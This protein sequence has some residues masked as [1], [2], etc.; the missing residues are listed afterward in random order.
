MRIGYLYPLVIVTG[1][2]ASATEVGQEVAVPAL[3][4]DAELEAANAL[5][6]VTF[7]LAEWAG[8]VTAGL[9]VSLAGIKPAIYLD[10]ATFLI[11]AACATALP[12]HTRSHTGPEPIWTQFTRGFGLLRHYRIVTVITLATVGF[13]AIDGALQVFWPVYSRRILGGGPAT[14]GI[15]ISAAGAGSL[16]S[17][18][19]LTT[20]M[21]KLPARLSL[22]ACLAGSGACVLALPAIHTMPVAVAAAIG[23]GVL[24]A[25]FYPISRAVLQRA[26]PEHHRGRVFGARVALT[27]W[28]PHRRRPRRHRADRRHTDHRRPGHRSHPPTHRTDTRRRQPTAHRTPARPNQQPQAM[29]SRNCAVRMGT[30]T[31]RSFLSEAAYSYRERHCLR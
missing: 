30:P 26:V 17:S 4:P 25:P 22:P 9:L 31:G 28:L 6:G 11:M 29:K 7:D 12:A 18:L 5:L 2:V 14:Y 19:T 13:L 23:V 21:A 24:A 3:V 15:L 27:T 1:L 10:S 8:P 20:I 16:A